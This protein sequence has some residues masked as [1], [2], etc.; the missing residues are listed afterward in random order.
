MA[1]RLNVSYHM[2]TRDSKTNENS[3]YLNVAK[4]IENNGCHLYAK[5][6]RGTQ[7]YA[8]DFGELLNNYVR[9]MNKKSADLK[10]ADIAR[11]LI[12]LN[13]SH[14]PVFTKNCDGKGEGE[15]STE[16]AVINTICEALLRIPEKKTDTTY[17]PPEGT[18]SKNELENFKPIYDY[19]QPDNDHAAKIF[20]VFAKMKQLAIEGL[21]ICNIVSEMLPT[22]DKT[23]GDELFDHIN[24]SFGYIT[25]WTFGEQY[26]LAIKSTTNELR[27]FLADDPQ[28]AQSSYLNYLSQTYETNYNKYTTYKASLLKL[29]TDADKQSLGSRLEQEKVNA[30]YLIESGL[31]KFQHEYEIKARNALDIWT[32]KTNPD[33]F[34][35]KHPVWEKLKAYDNN[36]SLT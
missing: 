14:Y 23:T 5:Y 22:Y 17:R 24:P 8:S 9:I 27:D 31:D 25:Y 26:K 3:L 29:L 6:Y 7:T 12:A 2:Y 19:L 21:S 35:E 4:M 34:P 32:A 28:N 36:H 33:S 18:F 30:K 11:G 15:P 13:S 16:S 20:D 1:K 10:T